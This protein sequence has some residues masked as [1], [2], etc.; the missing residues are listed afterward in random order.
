MN[1][2]FLHFSAY[3]IITSGSIALAS[4]TLPMKFSEDNSISAEM[5]SSSY[6]KSIPIQNECT[7]EKSRELTVG[8]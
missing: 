4:D 2:L 1:R 8:T 5:D 7:E 6:L 3:F